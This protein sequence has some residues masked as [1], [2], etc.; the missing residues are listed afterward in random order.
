MPEYV[1]DSS[2]QACWLIWGIRGCSLFLSD[3]SGGDVLIA[4]SDSGD[5]KKWII[6]DALNGKHALKRMNASSEIKY[7]STIE[8]VRCGNVVSVKGRKKVV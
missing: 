3:F 4:A 1:G 5:F 2:N 8:D 7:A 6:M